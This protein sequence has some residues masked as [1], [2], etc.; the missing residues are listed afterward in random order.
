[1]QCGQ[2]TFVT[3]AITTMWASV[4]HHWWWQAGQWWQGL[5]AELQAIIRWSACASMKC[6]WGT[7]SHT[8]KMYCTKGISKW[9]SKVWCCTTVALSMQALYI[10]EARAMEGSRMLTLPFASTNLCVRYARQCVSVHDRCEKVCVAVRHAFTNVLP[11]SHMCTMSVI[12]D[13]AVTGV[14]CN[15]GRS[16]VI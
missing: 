13:L 8:M 7:L 4:Q 10:P 3:M 2:V 15:T 14:W 6:E 12:T 1:M 16:N 11:D 9:V 5:R